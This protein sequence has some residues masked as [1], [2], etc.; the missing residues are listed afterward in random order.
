MNQP[1]WVGLLVLALSTVQT[2]WL[3]EIASRSRRRRAEDDEEPPSK[4]EGL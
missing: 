2:I 1:S 3:A 4:A